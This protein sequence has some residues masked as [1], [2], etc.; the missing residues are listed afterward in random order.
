MSLWGDE[1]FREKQFAKWSQNLLEEL[2][3]EPN[4]KTPREYWDEAWEK[5]HA[6]IPPHTDDIIK[7]ERSSPK[8]FDAE[9][10]KF[11]ARLKQSLPWG[12][13]PEKRTA[14]EYFTEGSSVGWALYCEKSYRASRVHDGSSD[15]DMRTYWNSMR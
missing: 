2:G 13:D 1:E 5:G 11:T 3:Y 4:L 15:D 14:K 9:L 12:D 8:D 7:L 10:A 6:F